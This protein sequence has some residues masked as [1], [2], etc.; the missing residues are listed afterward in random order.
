MLSLGQNQGKAEAVRQG[1]LHALAGGAGVVGYIDADLAT[2]VPE[3]KRLCRLMNEGTADV[4]RKACGGEEVKCATHDTLGREIEA[5]YVWLSDRATAV[6][7]MSAAAGLWPIDP[8]KR[9]LLRADTFGVGEM[10]KDAARRDAR[11]IL[12]GLGGSATNDGGFGMARALGYRFLNNDRVE[13]NG[14]VSELLTLHHIASPPDLILPRVT[15]AT[16]VRNPLLGMRGATQTFGP[17]KG[18]AADQLELFEAAL[19]R[20]AGTRW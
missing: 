5:S 6:M 18:V 1:L 3:I 11:E 13:I 4:I 8:G 17:Q 7:E 9:D 15:A 10:I 20:L 16:D 19:A 14:S 12:I 2:P